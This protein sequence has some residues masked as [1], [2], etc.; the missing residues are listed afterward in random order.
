M[1][2]ARLDDEGRVLEMFADRAAL[3][4]R[5]HP[6]FI[7]ELIDVPVHVNVGVGWHLRQGAWIDR[8]PAP[9]PT[10]DD[11]RA[12]ASRR[13]QALLGARDAGHLEILIANGT[14][15]AVRLLR[16]RDARAW[17]AEEARRAAELEAIDA[18]IE[19]IRSASN[20]LEPAPPADYAE[21]VRWPQ[22]SG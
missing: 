21:D 3:A 18:A 13:M 8:L 15:E 2:T 4:A 14:R 19:A 17:T 6:D 9:Q 16:V 22:S 10:A 12:E 1:R 5:F 20:V 11:V 7:A